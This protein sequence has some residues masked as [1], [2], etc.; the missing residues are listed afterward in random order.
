MNRSDFMRGLAV[1][2]VGALALSGIG[3][4][5]HANTIDQQAGNDTVVL[6]SQASGKASVKNGATVR[7]EAG[8]G[9]N[10]SQVTFQYQI[11]GASPANWQDIQTVSRND[12]GAFSYDWTAPTNILGATVDIQVVAKTAAG[13]D[14]SDSATSVAVSGAAD[15]VNI[16]NGSTLGVYQAPDGKNNLVV[17]GT[18][19]LADGATVTVSDLSGS[20]A[21]ADA[22]VKDGKF[23]AQLDITGYSFGTTDQIVVAASSATSADDVEAYTLKKQVITTVTASADRTN[24]PSGETAKVTVAVKD[25]DGNPIAGADVRSSLGGSATSAA[26]GTA[27]FTQGAGTAYYYANATDEAAYTPSLGDVK[28]SDIVV[29][30]YV[31]GAADLQG[32]SK[33]GNAFDFTE[34][35]AGD[36]TVKVLDGHGNPF[37]PTGQ[38]MTGRWEITPF[39][40]SAVVKLPATIAVAGSTGSVTFPTGQKEGTYVLFASLSANGSGNGAIAEKQVLSFKAGEAAITYDAASP[41]SALE[42]GTV[43]VKGKLALS[44]GTVL[45]NRVLTASYALGTD[46]SDPVRDAELVP[47]TGDRKTAVDGTFTVSVKDKLAEGTELNGKLTVATG[48]TPGIGNAGASGVQGVDFV[49]DQLPAGAV[50]TIDEDGAG[51]PG[52]VENGTVTVKDKDGNVLKGVQVTLTLDHGFFTDGSADPAPAKDGLQGEFKSLGDHISVVTNGSGVATFKTAIERDAGF[53]DDAK[54]TAKATATVD[55]V[56]DD[57]S[58]VWDT[59]DPLNY[60]E[61]SVEL[62]PAADQDGPV[63]PAPVGQSVWYDVFAK[64][65]YGNPV[66]GADVDIVNTDP[67]SADHPSPAFGGSGTSDLDTGGDFWV[68]SAKAGVYHFDADLDYTANVYNAA[69]LPDTKPAQVKDQFETEWYAAVPTDLSIERTPAGDSVELGATVS[70]TVTVIDQEGN[71]MPGLNV[72]FVRTGDPN[73]TRFDTDE[74]GQATYVF[75]A[76]EPGTETVTAVIRTGSGTVIDTLEDSFQVGGPVVEYFASAAN[77]KNGDDKVKVFTSEGAQAAGADVDLFK[78]VDGVWKQIGPKDAILGPNGRITF[79]VKDKNGDKVTKYRAEVDG[80]KTNKTSIN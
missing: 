58:I 74:A 19:T 47:V 65:Q 28:S 46:G 22:T 79:T 10:I 11:H 71:P 60:S 32:D 52:I 13:V 20:G 31:A 38:T 73:E 7:L 72:D 80:N 67:S 5:A 4:A 61:V 33:D 42:G 34:N 21:T 70:E 77:A 44:D 68:Y 15:T 56:S 49:T 78:K 62:A 63:D 2:A 9:A 12:D 76:S 23:T 48:S 26:D 64:D 53:D 55:G 51:T 40:G 25:A 57:D 59:T 50:V 45:P 14:V 37:T 17:H 27:T 30:P 39:D 66:V 3:S 8:A 29:T 18:T 75:R 24:V 69:K 1:S 54:V 36:I 6:Y 35:G 41:Q 43:D 16:D